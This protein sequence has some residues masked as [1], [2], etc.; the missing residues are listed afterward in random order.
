MFR[1]AVFPLV[2][3]AAMAP[4]RAAPQT[5]SKMPAPAS[6]TIDYDQHVKPIL[7]AKCF[8]CH[9]P[10]QQ[11]SG[12][13]L[14]LRQNA[15]R[16]GDYGVVIVPG[17]SAES[18]LILRL[19]GP[20]AGLQMPPTGAMPD[21]DIAI[22]RAWIDQG[23]NMPGRAIDTAVVARTTEPRIQMFI[24]LIH[25]HD[26]AA[27]RQALASDPLL[28]RAADAF[29]SSALMHAAY[30]GTLETMY[31]LLEEGAD[32]KARNERQ[33]TALHWAA[34]DP[35]KLKLLL[36]KGADINARTVERRTVLHEAAVQPAGDALV[37]TLLEA[38]AD[39]NARTIT[40]QTPLYIAVNASLAST[41]LLLDKGADPNAKTETGTTPLTNVGVRGGVALLVARGADVNV[42][43]KKG[44][45]ALGNAADRGDL[46]GV[47]VLLEHG[48]RVNVA[49]Y[50]GYTPLMFAAQYDRDSPE[51]VTLLLAHGADLAATGEN[52]TAVTLA[53]KK[54]DTQVT[55][56]LRDAQA[57]RRP[58]SADKR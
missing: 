7:A 45:S 1:V 42:L 56:L 9:G 46:E 55:R 18:K 30:A 53:A 27:V 25:R 50:R 3:L 58:T 52:E 54:G 14:D 41:R 38:G 20:T 37:A 13:R 17:K 15:M 6:V 48:A 28:A 29:G 10:T 36:A 26:A 8:G 57:G 51:L 16:G 35:A 19:T 5:P 39:V 21:D 49:N 23:G 4:A 43:D 24:D 34:S 31:A 11:Q 33:A 12:L 44:E 2:V 22:L 47:R 40:G 32:V